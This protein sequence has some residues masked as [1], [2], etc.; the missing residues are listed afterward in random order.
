MKTQQHNFW[1]VILAGLF[2]LPVSCLAADQT[3]EADAWV[4][5]NWASWTNEQATLCKDWRIDYRPVV[6]PKTN[7]SAVVSF[8][9][10]NPGSNVKGDV[11][12]L[13]WFCTITV[14]VEGAYFVR[15]VQ[16]GESP[17]NGGW[18]VWKTTKASVP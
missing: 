8:N 16:Q 5:K 3:D 12:K 13:V 17:T 10:M 2:Y 9:S 18:Q 6:E 1:A 7:G 15:L 4:S 11:T 14:T